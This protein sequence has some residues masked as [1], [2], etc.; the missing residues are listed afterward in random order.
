MNK[1]FESYLKSKSYSPRTIVDDLQNVKRF[2]LWYKSEEICQLSL[3]DQAQLTVPEL[4]EYINFLQQD[5]ISPQVINQRLRSIRKYYDYLALEGYEISSFDKLKVKGQVKK[6][7][8]DPLD[9]SDLEQLYSNYSI[10][11]EERQREQGKNFSGYKEATLSRKIMLGFMVFQGLKSAELKRV[12]KDHINEESGTL[13][14]PG[15]RRSKSRELKLL[16]SQMRPLF[17]LL[18][19]LQDEQTHLFIKD[20]DNQLFQLIQ[21][22]RGLNQKVQTATHIRASVIIHWLKL[23]GKRQVQYMIGHKWISS[24]EHYELQDLEELTSLLE[25]HHPFKLDY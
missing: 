18:D 5:R 2:L 9:Y 10:Y 23:H 20:V 19:A 11:R 6:V 17:K 24:T 22:L 3:E 21:E 25:A 12:E 8:V 15:S 7:I 14:L 16:S 4:V 13:F 1:A